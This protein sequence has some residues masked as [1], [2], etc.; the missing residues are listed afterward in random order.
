MLLLNEIVE[1]RVGTW[2]ERKHEDHA[3]HALGRVRQS[4]VKLR[5][6]E[7][8]HLPGQRDNVAIVVDDVPLTESLDHTLGIRARVTLVGPRTIQ[9]SEGKARR[10]L[11]HRKAPRP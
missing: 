4:R 2:T 10:V 7:R 3:L 5:F 6:R 9:R 11:D 1:I 8:V